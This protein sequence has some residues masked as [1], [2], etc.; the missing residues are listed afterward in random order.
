VFLFLELNLGRC[1]DLNDGDAAGQLGETLLE[2]L[3]IPVGIGRID[4]V[5]DLA[6]A[7]FDVGLL[8]LVMTTLRAV[9]SMSRVTPSSLR[10][11]SSA[12]T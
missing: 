1:A 2:L 8:S 6:D 11:I 10:P 9:P 5:L 4:L 3:A 12:M 7:T